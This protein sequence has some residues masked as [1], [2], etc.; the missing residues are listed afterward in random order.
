MYKFSS[1]VALTI[2]CKMKILL[3][4][5]F[6]IFLVAF[7]MGMYLKYTKHEKADV[8]LGLDVLFL[9]FIL[10]PLFIYHRHSLG[11]YKKYVLDGS[12]KNPFKIDEDKKI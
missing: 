6:V 7:I 9:A 10:M 11:K 5:L 3:R 4:I 1:F 2:F 8:V 12:K